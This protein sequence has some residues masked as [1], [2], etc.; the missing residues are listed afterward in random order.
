MPKK[1]EPI[2]KSKKI[3]SKAVEASKAIKKK[4]STKDSKPKKGTVQLKEVKA[5][6]SKS[7]AAKKAGKQEKE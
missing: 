4:Q 5:Y 6:R 3:S 2:E 1:K 7:K